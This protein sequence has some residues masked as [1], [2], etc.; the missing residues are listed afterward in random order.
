MATNDTPF[1]SEAHPERRVITTTESARR[2]KLLKRLK[3]YW[4]MEGANVV[5]LP[6][7]A[8]F[9]ITVVAEGQITIAVI[10]AMLATSFL[11]VVGTFA[12]KMVVDGLEGN[13]TSEEQWT[14]WLD[15]ARWPA[16]LLTIL[17]LIATV[18]EAISTLPR[19]S[20][21]LIG[22]S[23]LCLLAI[24]E[25]VNYYHVQLQHFDHAEDFQRLLSGKGFRRS[26]LSKS[27]CAYRQ[28]VRKV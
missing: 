2:D 18:V 17:A 28:R 21:S 12:W 16:M 19:F 4:M 27:I 11:L 15:L 8:W 7:I 3:P 1:S 14:P 6:L 25:F 10:T 20:A 22:A 23:L 24:L 5:L 13:P 26:H 9:L